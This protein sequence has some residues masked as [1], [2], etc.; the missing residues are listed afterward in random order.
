QTCALPIFD[1][2][3]NGASDGSLFRSPEH[4]SATASCLSPSALLL[5]SPDHVG[6]RTNHA[7]FVGLECP[8]DRI[9]LRRRSAAR[10]SSNARRD[11]EVCTDEDAIAIER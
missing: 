7:A 10:T 9:H 1:R 8:C 11:V 2:S 3:I 6:I 4:R 5:R